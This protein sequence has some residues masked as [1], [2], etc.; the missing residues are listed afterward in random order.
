MEKSQ[1]ANTKGGMTTRS[2]IALGVGLAGAATYGAYR[3]GKHLTGK[4]SSKRSWK[5]DY[6][7]HGK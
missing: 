1:P 4:T 6:G 3:L 2:K 5:S 7:R